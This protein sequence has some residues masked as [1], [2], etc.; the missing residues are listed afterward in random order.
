MRGRASASAWL[1]VGSMALA[2]CRKH[3]VRAATIR[4]IP[5]WVTVDDTFAGCAGG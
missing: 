2:S 3:T 4:H 1:L 5:P